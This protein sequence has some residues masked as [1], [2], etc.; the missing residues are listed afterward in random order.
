MDDRP[1]RWRYPPADAAQLR[2]GRHTAPV[3]PERATLNRY[4]VSCHNQR[5]KTAGLQLDTIDPNDVG[6]A[7]EAWEKV[8][9]KLQSG[10]MPPLGRPRPDGPA[11]TGMIAHLENALNQAAAIEKN[12]G[13]TDAI[14]RLNRTEYRNAVHDLLGLDIDPS[15]LPADEA[16]GNGFDNMAGSLTV[17]PALMERYVSSAR[18]ISQIV[19]GPL[20]TGLAV[21][22]YKTSPNY[23]QDDRVSE[24]LPFGSRGGLAVR[25][26]FPVEGD[27]QIK[28]R[29]QTSGLDY[30]RGIQRAHQLEVR[31]DGVRVKQ[32]S[33]G[34]EA[35]GKPA[36]L[37][38]SGYV[39]Q[40]PAWEKYVHTADAGLELRL[41]VKAGAHV[42][43]VSFARE[44][45]QQDGVLQPRQSA[46]AMSADDHADDNPGVDRVMISGPLAVNSNSTQARNPQ[47][48]VCQPKQQD[49][50]A[51]ARTIVS[52]LARHAYRRPVTDTDVNTLMT[53]YQSGRRD[54]TFDAGIKMALERVLASPDFLFRIERDPAGTAPNTPYRISDL[55]L[56]SRLSFFLWSSIPDE[57]LLDAASKGRLSDPAVLDKQVRRM[58]ADGRAAKAFV[59]NFG[60]Q[61]LLLR[62]LAAV[63]PDSMTYPAFDDNLREAFQRETELFLEYGLREDRSVVELLTADYTFVNERLARHYGI[64]NVYG[65]RFRKVPVDTAQRG[66]LLGQGS[67]LTVTSYANRTSPVVRGKWLLENIFGTPPPSPPPDVP[68]LPDKGNEGKPASVRARLEMHRKNPVCAACHAPMDPLGFALESF[69]GIGMWRTHEGEVPVDV[70]GTL[71]TG[72]TFHGMAELRSILLDQRELF[73]R[74]VTEKLLM[75][76]R[77]PRR[78]HDQPVI[79]RIT[80]DAATK[81]Y[82]WSAVILGIVKSTPFQMRRSA[83]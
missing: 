29:L 1:H 12:P 54:A 52:Q 2:A 17:T 58:L 38:F 69:D 13:R 61:W 20:P 25:H 59:D 39:I 56:A 75:R 8:I 14:H 18:K 77:P 31:V 7:A 16:G 78:V 80:A 70:S 41:P 47:L 65:N 53:F 30:V 68:P 50:A 67:L 46:R 63:T 74:T 64:P 19:V 55:E 32:F 15:L 3:T 5:L 60:G 9:Q 72:P 42:I 4:C 24:D 81:D 34:G 33:V 37:T 44:Q 49:E 73:V 43:A 21:V 27:Y 6:P 40:S 11:R 36:P 57:A 71:P 26:F 35:P 62:N 28:V 45:W 23:F 10:A 48:F 66:G 82:R 51:C 76:A 22:T 83:S 79:R